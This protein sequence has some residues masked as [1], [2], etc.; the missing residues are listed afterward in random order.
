[1]L[2]A[3]KGERI[4]LH[5]ELDAN[6]SQVSYHWTFNHSGSL[7]DNVRQHQ[8]PGAGASSPVLFY[9]PTVDQDY[10]T[11]ACYGTNQVGR[12][13]RPCVFQIAAAVRPFCPANCTLSNVTHAGFLR[14]ECVEGFDGG[15]PQWFL[16]QM[17]ELPGMQVRHNVT[18]HKGPPVFELSWAPA[19]GVS[20]Q[21]RVYAVNNKGLSDAVIIEDALLSGISPVTGPVVS[22]ALSPV[23]MVLVAI[24]G[25]LLLIGLSAVVA[26][27]VCRRPPAAELK[28]QQAAG[29]GASRGAN[30]S[31]PEG[32]MVLIVRSPSGAT[33]PV[34]TSGA[35]SPEDTDPDI[36]PSKHERRPLRGFMKIHRTPPQRRRRKR[37]D[38]GGGEDGDEDDKEAEEPLTNHR[39]S[40]PVLHST[41]PMAGH[42]LGHPMG[43]A[44]GHPLG[45]ATLPLGPKDNLPIN[46]VYMQNSFSHSN[47]S[48]AHKGVTA[49][50]PLGSIGPLGPL[51]SL[52]PVHAMERLMMNG[53]TK[54]TL[55]HSE[56]ITTSNRIQESCI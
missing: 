49:C 51:G 1:M 19:S 37:T 28:H 47:N 44:G 36:I 46:N 54:V 21:A 55:A 48:I 7:P 4:T 13:T 41:P 5:C 40:T 17:V 2:G 35:P 20:Y 11:L 56:P 52:G 25:S 10:G 18:L 3:V 45:H 53:S 24:S 34:I 29:A 39:G 22:Q 14:I 26:L 42:G 23:L 32:R 8:G 6:P 50:S 43:H 9:T 31:G 12:Q 27:Y 33:G 30:G 16:L 15:L 38:D